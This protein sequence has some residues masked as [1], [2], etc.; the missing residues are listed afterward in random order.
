MVAFAD[1]L[2]IDSDDTE[3]L[4][5]CGVCVAEMGNVASAVRFFT[6]ALEVDSAHA[7]AG[8]NLASCL[9]ALQT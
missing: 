1:G 4:V 5:N 8:E 6:A 9:A 7:R 3:L 2:D